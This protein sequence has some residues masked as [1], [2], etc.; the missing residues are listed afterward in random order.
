MAASMNEH[1]VAIIGAGGIGF[2]VAEF[3]TD[4]P[5]RSLSQNKENFFKYKIKTK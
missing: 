2:D 1:T 4:S 5:G 3:L